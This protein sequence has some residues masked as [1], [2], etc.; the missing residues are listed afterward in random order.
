MYKH[1]P[2]TNQCLSIGLG[3]IK[4]Y[5]AFWVIINN[6]EI[7]NKS[8]ISDMLRG[9]TVEIRN[10]LKKMISESSLHSMPGENKKYKF[11]KH[12][13]GGRGRGGGG[14]GRGGV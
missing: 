12:F 13:G 11:T 9:G 6:S 10:T 3:L 2:N 5:T 14:E 1:T 4:Q 8:K 7:L